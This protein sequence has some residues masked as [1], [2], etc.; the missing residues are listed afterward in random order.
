MAKKTSS[1][2]KAHTATDKKRIATIL[3]EGNKSPMPRDIKPMLATLVDAPFDADG[4][5]YEIKWD[6]YRAISYLNKGKVNIQS[7]NLKPFDEKFYPLHDELKTWKVNAVLDG[8]VIVAGPS[9]QA[10]FNLLQNWR[11]EADGILQYYVFDLLWYE[12]INLMDLPLSR[13]RQLLQSVLPESNLVHISLDFDTS[14]TQFY[15]TAEEMGLEGIMAKKTSSP[16]Q[17]DARNRDWLKI[18]T[19]LRQEVVIGGFTKN[20]GT[21]KPFSS[22][23]VGVYDDKKH[24]QYTGKIGTGFTVKKQRELMTLFKPLITAQSPFTSV[25]DVNKPSRFR[26]DPPKAEATWL[27]PEL[28]CEVA[29]REMTSDGVMRHPSFMGMREDKKP[30]EVVL[31]KELPAEAI[32][33]QKRQLGKWLQPAQNTDRK[34][35]LNPREKTQVKKINGH[36]ISFNNLDKYY[37][38][39]EKITKRDLLNYYY[40]IAPFILPYLKNRPQSLNRFPN[41]ITGKSFYQ[42]NVTGKVPGWA[43]TYP[44][45]SEGIQKNFLICND[46]ATLL[47]MASQGCIELNPWSSRTQK[48]DHPDWCVIDLDPDRQSFDQV[49]ETALVTRQVLLAGGVDSYCKT[50]GSTG[51]HIYFPLG[52]RYTY[53]ESKEF[54]RLIAH[55]VQQQL[56]AFTS[57]E[58]II[59]NRSGK[60]YVDFLQNRP[61]ATLATVYSLR[62]KPGAPVSMPLHWDEVKKGLKMTDYNIHNSVE[63]IREIAGLFQPVLGKGINMKQAIKKLNAAFKPAKK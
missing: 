59:K 4:W 15:H 21:S 25:P 6:G 10:D 39:K 1:T 13:R 9:G 24:L 22:L 38:P 12:G 63:R 62:P 48:P 20:E 37:W 30:K 33:Q 47:Y 34:T 36:S 61:G 54:G 31:E 18:K 60:L 49:I 51:L 19:Q 7:R 42:K 11:S 2:K 35:L 44:Y 52:A 5:L 53:E 29:Y 40:R 16:Y 32:L 50:S 8:E 28:L 3:K 46:E 26:P 45:T 56:P 43:K 27:Q 41:G 57:V 58:R 14:A 23:L 55:L 17:P